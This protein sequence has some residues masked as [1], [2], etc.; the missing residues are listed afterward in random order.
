LELFIEDLS[1]IAGCIERRDQTFTHFGFAQNEIEE[2]ARKLNG[3]GLDRL[4]PVGEA[5][6]FEAVWDGYDL[7]KQFTRLVSIRA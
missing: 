5:L 6:A 2:F 7:P 4:V 3:R 1:A